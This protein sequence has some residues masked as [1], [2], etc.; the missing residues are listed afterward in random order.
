MS[1]ERRIQKATKALSGELEPGEVVRAAIVGM[2][3]RNPTNLTVAGTNPGAAA[4]PGAAAAAAKGYRMV[5]VTD[6]H[7]YVVATARFRPWKPAETLAKHRLGEVEVRG[8]GPSVTVGDQSVSS[9]QLGWEKQ[10]DELV[11][12]AGSPTS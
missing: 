10:V 12:V 2:P 11:A 7:L 6:R 5:A 8:E 3:V 9:T 1:A 4:L